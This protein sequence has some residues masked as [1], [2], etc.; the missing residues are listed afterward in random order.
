ML[1]K[2]C[3][4]RYGNPVRNLYEDDRICTDFVREFFTQCRN[5]ITSC[6][7]LKSDKI[8]ALP[9]LGCLFS[10]YAELMLPLFN[11]RLREERYLEYGVKGKIM[12]KK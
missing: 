10:Q 6:Q 9:V 2:H 5:Y 7:E 8:K 11:A 1:S 3:K 12:K 4:T